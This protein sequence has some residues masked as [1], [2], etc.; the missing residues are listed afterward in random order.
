M[1]K[2]TLILLVI[3][4][5]GCGPDKRGDL[6]SQIYETEDKSGISSDKRIKEITNDIKKIEKDLESTLEKYKK[7]GNF[8]RA[9][10]IKMLHYKMYNKAYEHFTI[11]LEYFPDS[12]MLH[13][14]RGISAS[15]YGISQDL[16]SVRR[17]Y[18]NRAK[19]S[20]ENS[21]RINPR[22]VKGL[23][24]LSILYI[25]E[26]DR[27]DDAKP[28][29]DTLL[30]IS[31][32][33]FDAML[34]RALLHERDGETNDALDLYDRVISLSKNDEQVNIAITNRNKVLGEYIG[35]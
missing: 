8:H 26:L 24:A 19:I 4:L 23:Y 15:Q 29:L 17:D 2:I 7:N 21:I 18:I 14:Y 28:L 33:D 10:G 6:V 20:Y 35:D 34:V 1:K 27:I 32:R 3:I 16:D 22:F 9:L 31:T 11:A 25:Y 30:S 5:W 12:E 13:Y